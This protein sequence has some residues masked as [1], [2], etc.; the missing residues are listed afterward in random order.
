MRPTLSSDRSGR[1]CNRATGSDDLRGFRPE[2]AGSWDCGKLRW[3]SG[4][5]RQPELLPE[6]F[7]RSL[8]KAVAIAPRY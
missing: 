2:V 8:R 5:R 1:A 6:G 3:C 7:P 4:L